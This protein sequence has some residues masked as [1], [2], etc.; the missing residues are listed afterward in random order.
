[1]AHLDLAIEQVLAHVHPEDRP[2]L[3]ATIVEAVARGGAYARQYRVRRADGEYYWIEA[4][5]RVD[6]D[7]DGT[8]VSFPGIVIDV[9]ERRSLEEERNVATAALRESEARVKAMVDQSSAGVAQTTLDG[10]YVFVNDRYCSMVGRDREELLSLRMHA[11]THPEDLPGNAEQ[12]RNLAQGGRSFEIEK[13]YLRPDGS[14]IWVRNS[15]TGV[16]ERDGGVKSIF[17]VSLDISE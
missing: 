11:L 14:A 15:V 16:C 2:G 3:D 7:A 13:R 17:A 6:Y 8:P 10:Q 5:G 9:N 12:F 1:M 4:I